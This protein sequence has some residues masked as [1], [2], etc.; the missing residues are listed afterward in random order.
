LTLTQIA[1]LVEFT[2]LK[3]YNFQVDCVVHPQVSHMG[4]PMDDASHGDWYC[5]KHYIDQKNGCTNNKDQ[6]DVSP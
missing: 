4:F 1:I 5:S 6:P 3:N 2:I